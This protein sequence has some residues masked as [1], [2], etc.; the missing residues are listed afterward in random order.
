MPRKLLQISSLRPRQPMT[1]RTA[2]VA[3]LSPSHWAAV[4]FAGGEGRDAGTDNVA[5]SVTRRRPSTTMPEEE[6]SAMLP[7]GTRLGPYEIVAPLGAGGP[8]S[9]RASDHARELRRGLA[10]PSSR[11]P[12]NH[13]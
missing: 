12:G 8:A 7:A 13:V 1:T 9:V 6:R 11:G 5:T 10:K 2:K 3:R 4:S